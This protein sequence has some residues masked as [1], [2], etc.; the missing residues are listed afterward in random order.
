MVRRQVRPKLDDDIAA[1]GKR[2]GQAVVGHFC[3]PYRYEPRRFRR[4]T[5]LAPD[6][7]GQ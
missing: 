5:P 6:S 2:K 3:A 1:G 4:A 7:R